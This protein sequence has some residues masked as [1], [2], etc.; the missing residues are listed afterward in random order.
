MPD[1]PPEKTPEQLRC[2]TIDGNDD[3]TGMASSQ[4][5]V[6]AADYETIRRRVRE[7]R[8]KQPS[9]GVDVVVKFGRP[10]RRIAVARAV[11]TAA[12]LEALREQAGGMDR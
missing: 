1:T 8:A 3:P 5:R 9:A 6:L 7:L 2:F 4:Y 11:M 12:D 10:G